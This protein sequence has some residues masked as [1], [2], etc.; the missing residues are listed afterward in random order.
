MPKEYTKEELWKLYEKLP[1]ELKNA[2]FSAENADH[3][4]N[5]CERYE[6]EEIPKVAKLV[7]NVLLGIAVPEDF[8]KE[9][10]EELKLDDETARQ[11]TKEINRFIFYPVRP[12]LEQLHEIKVTPEQRPKEKLV[13][14]EE[15]SET[16]E[17][18]KPE[19]TEKQSAPSSQDSYRESIE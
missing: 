3:I 10:M 17:E 4:W 2:V 1:E 13:I 16:I 9:L 14:T 8:Q 6:I 18:E 12:V 7:S 15:I 19:T 5:I 11:V